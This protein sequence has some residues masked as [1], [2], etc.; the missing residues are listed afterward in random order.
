[1]KNMS[2]SSE[3]TSTHKTLK[4]V[5][6]GG[7]LTLLSTFAKMGLGL[8]LQVLIIRYLSRSEFGLFSMAAAVAN[9]LTVFST[10]GLVSALPAFISHQLAKENYA[11]ARSAISVSLKITAMLSVIVSLALFF[12]AEFVSQGLLHKPALSECIKIFAFAVPLMAFM[13]LLI[14]HVRA[15]Q[16]V[17]GKVYFKDIMRPSVAIFLIILVVLFGLSFRW[18]LIAYVASFLITCIAL[19]VYAKGKLKAAIPQARLVSVTK[20]VVMFSLPLLG[21][22]I[23]AQ[24]M[25]WTD[26]LILGRFY[27]AEAVGLY[28]AAL[29]IIQVLPTML[30]AAVF[31]YLPAASRLF[32]KNDTEGVRTIYAAITKWLLLMT[33]P[34]FICFL[35]APELVLGKLLGARYI[36][37]S[38]VLQILTIGIFAF[39]ALGPNSQT[40]IAIGKPNINFICLLFSLVVNVVLDIIFI[41]IYGA[42]G[43]A[44]VSTICMILTNV[45]V[46]YWVYRL[47]RVHPFTKNYLKV[48]VPSSIMICAVLFLGHA[49][50]LKNHPG[51]I[52]LLAVVSPAIVFITR[53]I[54]REDVALFSMF[55][56]KITGNTHF[57]EKFFGKMAAVGEPN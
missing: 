49:G 13:N 30:I 55:E 36:E 10:F 53:S 39:I 19:F 45:L 22:G 52:V 15:I 28:N 41:P 43:A 17:G 42:V 11:K 21:T 5:A 50:I 16:Q 6:K 7:S 27:P 1:M 23:V 20:E 51:L 37:A 48:V 8:V 57:T 47:S 54:D 31:L 3:Y 24:L 9:I 18:L 32:S 46:S 2:N 44:V 14:S 35:G 34:L 38:Y 25:M 33:L 26:T 40:I 56:R 12:G 4:R 29:R